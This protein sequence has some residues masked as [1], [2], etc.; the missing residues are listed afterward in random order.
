M[1]EVHLET[2]VSQRVSRHAGQFEEEKTIKKITSSQQPC[3]LASVGC[4]LAV[5]EQFAAIP[6]L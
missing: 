5:A 6:A 3:T 1:V 4:P 2:F